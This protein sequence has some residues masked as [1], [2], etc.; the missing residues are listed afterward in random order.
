MTDTPNNRQS[1]MLKTF[2]R[3][4]GRPLSP[5]Q[6]AL[7]DELYPRIEAPI[8]EGATLDPASLFA[9]KP[10]KVW[11]EIGFGG[12]EHL[13]GQAQEHPDIGLIGVEPFRESVGKAL[14]QIDIAKLSNIRIHQGDAREVLIGIK[15]ETLDRIFILFPDPWPKARHNKRRIVQHE[16]V[17]LFVSRL[18]P[19]GSLRFATDVAHYA[20]WALERFIANEALEWSAQQADDWRTPPVDHITTRYQTKNLG[21]CSPVFYDFVKRAH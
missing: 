20:D 4:G 3:A 10:Q 7:F 19:G 12:A 8:A 16:S 17:S 2:G 13:V 6:K 21:D 14:S 15:P 18:K 1:G 5:R 9:R 11:F